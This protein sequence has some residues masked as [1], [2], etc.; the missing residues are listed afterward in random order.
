MHQIV[1]I[2][3]HDFP[4]IINAAPRF[5]RPFDNSDSASVN[6]NCDRKYTAAVRPDLFSIDLGRISLSPASLKVLTWQARRMFSSS[7]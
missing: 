3:I 4:E 2:K 6:W 7:V 5:P 1:R